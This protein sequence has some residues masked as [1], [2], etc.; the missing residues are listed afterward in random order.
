[1]KS[2][3]ILVSISVLVASGLVQ[4]ADYK[5]DPAHSN[6]QFTIRH[7]VSRVSGSFND[8]GGD[9]SF[10]PHHLDATKLVAKVNVASINTGNEKRDGHLKSPDF[11]D[12]AKHPTMN[13]VSRKL[14]ADGANKY[15]LSGDL[16][17]HG[18][19]KPVVLDVEFLGEGT[20]P[21][22]GKRAGFVATGKINRKDFGINWNKTL[23]SGGV[24]LGEDVTL[25][26]NIEAAQDSGHSAAPAAAK[27]K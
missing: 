21:Q 5:I 15:K 22:G 16:T 7:L 6:L 20:D 25:N 14:E 11:F 26:V 19:T 2:I 1:M 10:D 12:V 18:V 24:V 3:R 8:F 9:F 23:D 27:K 17:L 4:A 13:F